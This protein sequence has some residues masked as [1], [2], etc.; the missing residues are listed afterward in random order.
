M[1]YHSRRATLTGATLRPVY[2]A[3]FIFTSRRLLPNL[4]V[5]FSLRNVFN[6]QYSDPVALNSRVDRMPQRGRAVVIQLIGRAAR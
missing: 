1:Q 4:D 2:L 5:Q 3:D 6:R